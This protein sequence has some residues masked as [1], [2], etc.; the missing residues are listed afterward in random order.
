MRTI[1]VVIVALLLVSSG[2]ATASAQRRMPGDEQIQSQIEQRLFDAGL[3]GVVVGVHDGQVTLS[4]TVEDL[5]AQEAAVKQAEK[6]RGVHGVVTHLRVTRPVS[7]ADL[8]TAIGDDIAAAPFLTMF[9]D[10]GGVVANGVATLTGNVTTPDKSRRIEQLVSGVEGVQRIVNKIEVL[11]ASL[12]DDE[13]R[14]AIAD[15]IYSDPALS[16]YGVSPP[17]PVHI[18]VKGGRVTLVGVV[19]S[20]VDRRLA[21]MR[22]REVFGVR[23]VENQLRVG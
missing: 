21:E 11:P 20:E 17:F 15:R 16:E 13:I 1:Q 10:V 7:G 6:V 5:A 19:A 8:A 4:G 3:I 18:I 22:A 23:G 12:F 2:V 14:S 9:D